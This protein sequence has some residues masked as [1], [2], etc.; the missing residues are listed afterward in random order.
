MLTSYQIVKLLNN[1]GIKFR[2]VFKKPVSD[3]TGEYFDDDDDDDYRPIYKWCKMGYN[4][5][6]PA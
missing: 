3:F 4:N 6:M 1:E 5:I 2:V